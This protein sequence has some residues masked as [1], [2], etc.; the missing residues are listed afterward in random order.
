MDE[1]RKEVSN[2]AKRLKTDRIKHV[3]AVYYQ[4]RNY[5]CLMP[6]DM[7]LEEFLRFKTVNSKVSQPNI[8]F[9]ACWNNKEALV[10]DS[11][12]CKFISWLKE[13]KVKNGPTDLDNL[14]GPLFCYMYLELLRKDLVDQATAFFRLH[15]S[16]V[17]KSKCDTSVKELITA[18]ASN[19]VELNGI[20]DTFRSNK[21][22]VHLSPVSCKLLKRF[23]LAKCHV[24]FLQMLALWFQIHEREEEDEA[25]SSENKQEI[26]VK[27]VMCNGHIFSYT[28]DI[29][30]QIARIKSESSRLYTVQ[31]NNVKHDITC[32]I[33]SRNNGFVAYCHNNS[34]HIRS[35][36]TLR[37]L[38]QA[39]HNEIIFR[40]HTGRIYDITI[41]DKHNLLITAS[42]DRNISL[43]NLNNYTRHGILKGHNYPVYSLATSGNGAYL[44]SGSYDATIRLWSLQRNNTLRVYSGHRQEITSL[45]FHPNSVYF[46]SSS[47]D[48]AVRMWTVSAAM[49]VRLLYGSEGPVYCVRISPNG[50]LIACSGEDKV[51]RVWDILASKQL[52][53]LK[54]GREPVTEICWSGDQKSLLTGSLNGIV[55]TW[56]M[57]RILK[58]PTDTSL[59]EPLSCSSLN[60][61]LLHVE[62]SQESFACLI[63]QNKISTFVKS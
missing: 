8:L 47:A 53:E 63:G 19:A 46:A 51:L 11:N 59:H 5:K 62:Y 13:V 24:V 20:K 33:I 45:D 3:M 42:F 60:S 44:I 16:S 56:N 12:Y 9:F 34:T 50:R 54:C 39:K 29:E 18:I 14:T 15:V 38:K 37:T 4:K 21:Y 28:T 55:C 35:L 27:N 17:D 23:I 41:A 49:P 61:K 52:V 48:K 25:P 31:L 6:Q 10:I 57:D 7:S 30:E 26:P 43:Y 2:K 58:N 1:T 36:A 22:V 40:N 32:G